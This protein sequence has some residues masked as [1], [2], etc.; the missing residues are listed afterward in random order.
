[1]WE[2]C[3]Y[4]NSE[5]ES[6]GTERYSRLSLSASLIEILIDIP[7][8]GRYGQKR[9]CTYRRVWFQLMPGRCIASVFG[10]AYVSYSNC[11]ANSVKGVVCAKQRPPTKVRLV[12]F[13]HCQRDSI[14][15][16]DRP[17]VLAGVRAEM[18]RE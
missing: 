16:P 6:G 7:W 17:F 13:M 3:L 10:L 8:N 18:R 11:A 12:P 5:A 2:A 9:P 14:N 1:M 15:E 4:D